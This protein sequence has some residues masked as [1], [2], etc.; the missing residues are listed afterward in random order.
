M[1][2]EPSRGSD[3]KNQ[4]HDFKVNGALTIVGDDIEIVLDMEIMRLYRQSSGWIRLP[5]PS[6]PQR[7]RHERSANA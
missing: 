1:P 2:K 6:M 4:S 3:D 7:G 5:V